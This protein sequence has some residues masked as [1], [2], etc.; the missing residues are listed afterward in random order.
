MIS[1]IFNCSLQHT[2]FSP[3]KHYFKYKIYTYCLDLDELVSVNKKLPLFG[4]NCFRPTSIYDKD[5]LTKDNTS[6]K[7]KV[8]TFVKD[9]GVKVKIS[10]V[11]LITSAKYLGYVFNPVSFYYCFSLENKVVAIVAEVNNTFGEK[12]LY[13]LQKTTAAKKENTY[14]YK[15]KKVFHV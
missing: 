4:Y 5:Y 3:K 14:N 1:Q 6:I 15:A 12:H 9:A 8:I 13:I 11:K 2:R 10:K 7:K